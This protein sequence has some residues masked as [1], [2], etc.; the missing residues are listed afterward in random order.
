MDYPDKMLNFLHMYFLLQIRITYEN[1]KH[2]F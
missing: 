1:K 2:L